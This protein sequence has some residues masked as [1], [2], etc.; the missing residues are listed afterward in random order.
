MPRDIATGKMPS[1]TVIDIKGKGKPPGG[2]PP[3]GGAPPTDEVASTSESDF[4]CPECGANLCATRKEEE[5][6]EGEGGGEIP[7]ARGGYGA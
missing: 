4:K 3:D 2:A 5:S 1:V 7:P 6:S